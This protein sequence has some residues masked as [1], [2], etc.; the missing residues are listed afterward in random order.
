MAFGIGINTAKP[1]QGGLRGRQHAIA[2]E[3]WF[4]SRGEIVPRLFKYVEGGEVFTVRDIRVLYSEQK[5]YAGVSSVEYCCEI[6]EQ[7]N[8]REVKLVFF[9]EEC[10]WVL[11]ENT[12]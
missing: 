5:N 9:K 10:R 6:L 1:A 7:G 3:C 12:K 11:L 2:C 4:N 8:V